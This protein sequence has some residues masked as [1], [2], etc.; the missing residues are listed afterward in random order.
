MSFTEKPGSERNPTGTGSRGEGLAPNEVTE[1]STSLLR[2]LLQKTRAKE[3]LPAK[4]YQVLTNKLRN[5]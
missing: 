5:E 1:L 3:R 4:P 2:Q